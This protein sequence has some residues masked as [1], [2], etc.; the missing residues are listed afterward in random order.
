MQ[1]LK[2]SFGS[3]EFEYFMDFSQADDPNYI[4][5]KRSE[6]LYE[7][8]PDREFFKHGFGQA[9]VIRDNNRT[10]GRIYASID[11]LLVNTIK[12]GVFGYFDCINSV[13]IS[14]MLL[15]AA[16]DWLKDNGCIEIHGP[17]NLNIYNGYRFQ[18][19]GFE[20]MPFLGE[21]RSPEYYHK[22]V[23]NS[24]FTECAGWN[25]WDFNR[26]WGFFL[27]VMVEWQIWKDNLKEKLNK[28][29]TTSFSKDNIEEEFV[30][31]YPLIMDSFKN[32]YLFC[33]VS[34]EEYKTY[35]LSLSKCLDSSSAIALDQN[36]EVAGFSFNY[37]N[38]IS[39]DHT[40]KTLVF[41]TICISKKYQ[42]IGLVYLIHQFTNRRCL[43]RYSSFIGA[44]AKEGKTFYDRMGVASRSYAVY[45]KT[46]S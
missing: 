32:N 5:K 2:V 19:K 39:K 42:K 37:P 41:H 34:L 4:A 7:L 14:T 27:V 20:T 28:F 16:E 46:I 10:L 1:I 43:G 17:V 45:K 30:K 31:L 13:E 25:S 29:R 8:S 18:T 15:K 36:N 12:I 40:K 38:L 22:L 26:G 9:F 44:L 23:L 6:I 3:S 11:H 21:P 35:F 33:K 24:G